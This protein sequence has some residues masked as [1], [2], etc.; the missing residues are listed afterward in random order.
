M[1]AVVLELAMHHTTDRREYFRAYG[2]REDRR[3]AVA[4]KT[5]AILDDVLDHYGAVCACCGEKER[6]F[7]TLDHVA[8]GGNEW[9]RSVRAHERNGRGLYRWIQKHGYPDV[10]R[11]LCMNCNMARGYYGYC[12]HECERGECSHAPNDPDCAGPRSA[13]ETLANLG[14][15]V[16][17][18]G[19]KYR[20]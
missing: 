15:D 20:E 11:V 8:G 12:P 2:Q 18:L 9:R 3:S 17:A 10:F 16:H 6:A 7:L 14:R 4:A 5:A 19:V 1:I 13:F